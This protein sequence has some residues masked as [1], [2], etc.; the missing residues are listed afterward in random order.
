MDNISNLALG[1]K[2]GK[3]ISTTVLRLFRHQFFPRILYIIL[4]KNLI[5]QFKMFNVEQKST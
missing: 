4:K 1:K 5:Q 2:K 3:D